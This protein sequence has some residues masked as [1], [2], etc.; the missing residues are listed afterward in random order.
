MDDL[1]RLR[2][3]LLPDGRITFPDSVAEP[4]AADASWQ[5]LGCVRQGPWQMC[6]V[7]AEIGGESW[8]SLVRSDQLDPRLTSPVVT[9]R[10]QSAPG[11]EPL[12]GWIL[13]C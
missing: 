8:V 12:D 2:V 9:L 3:C 10:R 1:L 13:F 7:R 5:S 4:D 6:F 11:R